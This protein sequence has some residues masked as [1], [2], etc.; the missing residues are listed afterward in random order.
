MVNMKT[1]AELLQEYIDTYKGT[2]NH[3]MPT[4]YEWLKVLHPKV[5]ETEVKDDSAVELFCKEMKAK[6]SLARVKGRAGWYDHDRC[7]GAELAQMLIDQIHK[8]NKGCFVDIANFAMMLHMRG[9]STDVLMTTSISKE[10][11]SRVIK[12]HEDSTW[13]I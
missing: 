6:L 10:E 13:Y 4:F 7:S 1:E 11:K 8:A 12:I 3:I 2:S 5:Y 9:E